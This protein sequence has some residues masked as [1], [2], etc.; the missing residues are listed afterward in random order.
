MNKQSLDRLSKFGRF[1]GNNYMKHV[2]KHNEMEFNCSKAK[3][4]IE[5]FAW[6]LVDLPKFSNGK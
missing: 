4:G 3:S 6:A 1:I 5:H 2:M